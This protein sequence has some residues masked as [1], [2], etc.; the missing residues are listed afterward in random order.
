M[1]RLLILTRYPGEYEPQR[2]K[3]EAE[4]QN[5]KAKVLSYKRISLTW[6]DSGVNVFLGG[7]KEL[8]GYHY[9]IPRAASKKGESLVALK[10]ALIGLLKKNQRCLN[11]ET[12]LRYPLTSK[13]FQG[14][15]LAQLGLPV[16]PSFVFNNREEWQQF[17]AKERLKFPLIIKAVF[18]SH[19]RQVKLVRQWRQANEFLGQEQWSSVIAQPLIESRFWLRVLVLGDRI[20]GAVARKTKTRF[21]IGGG[22]KVDHTGKSFSLDQAGEEIC[23]RAARALKSDFCGLDLIPDPKEGW[24]IIEVN[25][26]PQFKIFEQKTDFNVAAQI[27]QFLTQPASSLT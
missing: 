27:I 15:T 20:L 1:K 18:G 12:F 24:L 4:G 14:I 21:L 17:L 26:T 11:Q 9:L 13:M 23:L 6:D 22:V 19:G 5:L 10:T 2:L 8:F 25:R 7:K 16:I 3:Q